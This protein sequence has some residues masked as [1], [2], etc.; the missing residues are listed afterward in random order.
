MPT[1]RTV[2]KQGRFRKKPVEVDAMQVSEIITLGEAMGPGGMPEWLV[3]AL[4]KD[5]ETDEG[6]R[7]Q[8]RLVAHE[9]HVSVRTIQGQ[10]ID[11]EWTEWIVCGAPDDLW[12][13]DADVFAATYEPADKEG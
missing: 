8:S 10:W 1:E 11:A 2:E 13:V 3:Q 5:P 6:Y 12:P 4:S 7:A 9:S